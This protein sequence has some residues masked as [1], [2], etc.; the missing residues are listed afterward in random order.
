MALQNLNHRQSQGWGLW[1]QTSLY[2]YY[3]KKMEK[4]EEEP[5]WAQI[6]ATIYFIWEW[7]TLTVQ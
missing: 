5:G 3:V 2:F 4:A 6:E 7:E 1:L